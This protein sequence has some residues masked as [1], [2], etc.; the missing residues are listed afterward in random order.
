MTTQLTKEQ[1]Q[2]SELKEFAQE[3]K[4]NGF[5]VLVSKKHPFKWLYFYK[6]GLF[7]NVNANHFFLYDFDTVHKPCRECGT[8]FGMIQNDALTIEN[9]NKSLSFAPQWAKRSQLNAIRKYTSIEDFI[10]STHN[11]WAEYYIL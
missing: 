2:I 8:G 4:D 9:A 7:G 6:D 1:V 10:N 11:Q 3:L 5:T